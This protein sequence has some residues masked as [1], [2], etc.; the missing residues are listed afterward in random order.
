VLTLLNDPEWSKLSDR[1]IAQHCKVD[2][3]TVAARR[4]KPKVS[5]EIPQMQRRTVTRNGS[6][7]TM[8]TAAIGKKPAQPEPQDDEPPLFPEAAPPSSSPLPTSPPPMAPPSPSLPSTPKAVADAVREHFGHNAR[9]AR[10]VALELLPSLPPPLAKIVEG[11]KAQGRKSMATMSP[12]TVA[13]LADELEA[14][15]RTDDGA[16]AAADVVA[17]ASPSP[18]ITA[19]LQR[20]KRDG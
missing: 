3:K 2:H 7:Y 19:F 12:G 14:R 4:P 1:E 20:P 6:T 18:A 13:M 16:V 10:A 15:L 5:G 11:L 9:K 17:G 8:D